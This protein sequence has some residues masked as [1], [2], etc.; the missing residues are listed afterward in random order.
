MPVNWGRKCSARVHRGILDPISKPFFV[1][2]NELLGPGEP[3]SL[4]IIPSF[5]IRTPFL[6]LFMQNFNHYPQAVPL[7]TPQNPKMIHSQEII[8]RKAKVR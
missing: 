2:F 5:P 6:A 1:L 3:G 8:E 7:L 4:T